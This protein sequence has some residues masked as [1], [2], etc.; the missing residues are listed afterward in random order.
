MFGQATV[1]FNDRLDLAAG[2]RFDYEDKSALLEKFFEPAI[3]PA[4]QG[5]GR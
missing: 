3:A 1:T 5:R 4:R 2:A